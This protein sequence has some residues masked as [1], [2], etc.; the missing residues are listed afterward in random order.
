MRVSP[1]LPEGDEELDRAIQAA[2]A[3]PALQDQPLRDLLER[4]W[5]RLGRQVIRLERITS[6]S[7]HY[8]S[9]KQEE[10]QD[11]TA[12]YERQLRLLERVIRISD[13]NQ[14]A[15]KQ[16]NQALQE[17]STHDQ[18][19]GLANRR[20][21]TERCRQE[22]RRSVRFAS[23]YS[24]LILDADYFK[25]VNDNHGHDVGDQVLVQLAQAF[26]AAL[27]QE[28]LCSR[29][30]GEEFLALLVQASHEDAVIVAERTLASIRAVRLPVAGGEIQI[31]ASIGIAEHQAGETYADTLRR[32]DA[33]L[34]KAK[35]NGRNRLELAE[36]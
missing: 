24:L 36:T 7:D 6:I 17:A 32:A 21:M 19:T 12:R 29:W 26:R 14:A 9:L 18:L 25:R 8:Q 4:L 22:D 33:A 27:R 5:R 16:L 1:P 30:G 34:L 28:D 20:C 11:L 35:R 13:R 10:V 15:L 3:E 2:L 31:T 23:T